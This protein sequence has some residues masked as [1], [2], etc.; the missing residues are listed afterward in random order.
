MSAP[1]QLYDYTS[2]DYLPVGS[3]QIRPGWTGSVAAVLPGWDT[4][5]Q[6]PHNISSLYLTLPSNT[7]TAF[8]VGFKFGFTAISVEQVLVSFNDGASGFN[9][10]VGVDSVNRLFVEGAT[11]WTS[12]KASRITTG[13]FYNFEVGVSIGDTGAFHVR[14]DGLDVP[15]LILSGVD[16]QARPTANVSRVLFNGANLAIDDFWIKVGFDSFSESDLMTDQDNNPRIATLRPDADGAHVEWTNATGA[17]AE[18]LE[19]DELLL[20]DD[21]SYLSSLTLDQRQLVQLSDMPADVATI[22]DLQTVVS[23]RTV[24]SAGA[25]LKHMIRLHEVDREHL[26]SDFALST[27][28]HIPST[29]RWPVSPST[30]LPWT[31]EEVDVLEAGF[32]RSSATSAFMVRA[33]QLVVEAL[34][35]ATPT[36]TEKDIS[37]FL[38]QRTHRHCT[39]WEIRRTDGAVLRFTDHSTQLPI[40]SKIFSPSGGFDASA[41]RRESRL[42]DTNV[43]IRGAINSDRITIEDL[44]AERYRGAEVVEFTVDWRYPWAGRFDEHRWWIGNVV[45]D[46]EAWTAQLEGISR[47]LRQH[48]GKVYTRDC[49][50]YFGSVGCGVPVFG[51]TYPAVAVATV[52]DRRTF[53]LDA[54]AIPATLGDDWFNFGVV[55]FRSGLNAGLIAEVKDYVEVGRAVTLQLKLPFDIAVGDRVDIEPGCDLLST[56]CS[57]KYKNLLNYQGWFLFGPGTDKTLQTPQN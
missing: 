32:R 15:D 30:G 6:A 26:A 18:Y 45:F 56:T 13:R 24:T 38:G 40:G 20:D 4:N 9:L 48:A 16:T 25:T 8:A 14:L 12:S 17:G 11:R 57:G 7:Y 39:C 47:W 42:R 52:T 49:S 23:A 46:G 55:R 29:R 5:G 27:T 43:E 36:D 34:Y 41:R 2:W 50:A 33:S 19:L 53:E 44:L 10:K 28:L 54:A 31:K 35:S 21:T 37:G 22:H 3:V 51:L 1:L